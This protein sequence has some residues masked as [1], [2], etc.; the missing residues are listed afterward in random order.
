MA[1]RKE[2]VRNTIRRL[3][4]FVS[5]TEGMGVDPV[6]SSNYNATPAARTLASY[7]YKNLMGNGEKKSKYYKEIPTKGGNKK[8][9]KNLQKRRLEQ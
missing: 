8:K 3:L 6:S 5:G 7:G 4:E 9:R 1:T 2:H